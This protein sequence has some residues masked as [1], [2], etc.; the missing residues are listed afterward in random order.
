VIKT[1][2]DSFA[3]GEW[4]GADGDARAPGDASLSQNT[5]CDAYGCVARLPDGRFIALALSPEAFEDDCR[6]A[7]VVIT[8]GNEPASCGALTNDRKARQRTGA[9]TLRREGD[10]FVVTPTRPPGYDRPWARAAPSAAEA[11][12][13]SQRTPPA[14]RDATPRAEDL[15]SGD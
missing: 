7:A 12:A 4:L 9:V 13:V 6:R 1:G 5:K 11:D 3:V 2:S 14:A 15:E 8:L 10:G